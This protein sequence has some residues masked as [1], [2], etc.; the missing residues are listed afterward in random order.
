MNTE[1][2]NTNEKLTIEELR[3]FPG[4]EHYTDEQAS[5]IVETIYQLCLLLFDMAAANKAWQADEDEDLTEI[6]IDHLNKAA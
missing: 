3:A 1:N 2:P 4:C 6:N 5:E